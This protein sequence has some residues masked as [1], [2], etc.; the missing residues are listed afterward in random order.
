MIHPSMVNTMNLSATSDPF[1]KLIWSGPSYALIVAMAPLLL[2]Q[3]KL[4]LN[5][6]GLESAKGYS[7]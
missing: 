1:V 2:V 6:V 3:R 4:T 5:F 7:S